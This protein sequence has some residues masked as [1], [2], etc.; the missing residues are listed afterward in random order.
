MS[1]KKMFLLAKDAVNA[2]IDD[3]AP[4]MGAAISYYTVFSIAP[5]L[6]IV[7]VVAGV[8]FGQEAVR[9]SLQAQMSGL[10]GNDGATAIQALVANAYKPGQ[11]LVASAISIAVLLVGATTVFA[12][13]QSS[14]DR[15]W[16]VPERKKPSGLWGILRAVS[17]L[18]THPGF[19][20]P[21]DDLVGGQR[22]HLGFWYMVWRAAAW[23]GASAAVTK[24]CDQPICRN[25][26]LRHDLQA[27]AFRSNCLA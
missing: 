7:T 18:R 1:L 13:L 10:V 20:L 5:L 11:S 21:V 14:L 19:R 3:F 8:V 25:P 2:W 27:Y 9:G 15:V 6:L 17:V 23:V 24:H 16:H 4:S 12:E 22:R 26:A